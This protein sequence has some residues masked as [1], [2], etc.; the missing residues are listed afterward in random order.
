MSK[1]AQ[2]HQHHKH[3]H[4]SQGKYAFEP[5]HPFNMDDPKSW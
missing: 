2:Q 1:D 5:I 3:H 4:Q